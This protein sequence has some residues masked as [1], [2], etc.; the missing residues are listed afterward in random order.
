MPIIDFSSSPYYYS[1]YGILVNAPSTS[2]RKINWWG[3]TDTFSVHLW[4]Y[5]L[6]A[7]MLVTAVLHGVHACCARRIWANKHFHDPAKCVMYTASGYMNQ[8]FQPVRYDSILPTQNLLIAG[9]V[10]LTPS[11][12]WG[13]ILLSFWWFLRFLEA[14]SYGSF[15]IATLTAH[16]PTPLPFKE[17]YGL[18]SLL[19]RNEYK[20]CIR[21]GTSFHQQVLQVYLLYP[22]PIDRSLHHGVF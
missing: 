18:A 17:V 12:W 21:G 11:S 6:A 22:R 16:A 14:A 10:N 9:A 5:F 3:W 1:L 8:G 2:T 13:Q 19:D 15:L 4:L 20:M 7:L